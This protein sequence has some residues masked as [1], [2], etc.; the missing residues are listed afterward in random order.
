[1]DSK[2]LTL[3][4]K[5][6]NRLTYNIT[7]DTTTYTVI[8]RLK[9]TVENVTVPLIEVNATKLTTATGFWDIDLSPTTFQGAYT[10]EIELNDGVN[11]PIFYG[12]AP[13]KC[14]IQVRLD[15]N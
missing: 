8:F 1:M 14:L 11:A 15:N 13:Q 9:K 2:I 3:N 12:G 4:A 7:V 5:E 10:Y 6:L